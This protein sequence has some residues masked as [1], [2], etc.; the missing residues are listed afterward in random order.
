MKGW[1]QVEPDG[2]AEDADLRRWIDRG[3]AYAR[4]RPPK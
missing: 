4:G 3:V 1:L 2:C